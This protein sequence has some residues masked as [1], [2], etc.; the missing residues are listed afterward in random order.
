MIISGDIG[1]NRPYSDRTTEAD[2]LLHGVAVRN[3]LPLVV[4]VAP[5]LWLGQ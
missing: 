1:A 3:Q 5:P 4:H 2:D